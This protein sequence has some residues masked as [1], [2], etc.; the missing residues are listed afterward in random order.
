MDFEDGKWGIV[1]YCSVQKRTIRKGNFFEYSAM[2]S[3][4]ESQSGFSSFLFLCVMYAK[5]SV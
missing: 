2:W 5:E 1:L 4:E 3:D